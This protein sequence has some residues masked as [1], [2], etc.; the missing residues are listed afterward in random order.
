MKGFFTPNLSKIIAYFFLFF[1]MPTYYYVCDAGICNVKVSFFVILSLF[2]GIE[3]GTLT[4]PGM[5]LLIIL[6]Y[7]MACFIIHAATP[8]I[9]LYKERIGVGLRRKRI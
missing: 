7:I 5:L 1:L 8:F 6:S 9:E 4:F 2:Y 3:L